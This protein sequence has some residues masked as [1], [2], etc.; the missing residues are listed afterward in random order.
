MQPIKRNWEDPEARVLWQRARFTPVMPLGEDN[1]LLTGSK[2]HIAR[3]R[4][5][6]QEGMVL[7]KNDGTLP[8]KKGQRIAVFGAAQTDYMRG[9]TGAG[10]VRCA[11]EKTLLDGLTEKEA[12][13]KL[14][15]YTPLSQ[16]Y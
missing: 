11:F 13:G 10:I 8:L 1:R 2:E 14:E 9:G 4:T 16:F 7:L 5:V 12:E 15:L 3:T 6:A